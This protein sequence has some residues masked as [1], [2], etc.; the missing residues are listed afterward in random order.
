MIAMSR[1]VLALAGAAGGLAMIVAAG[2][3]RAQA[4][5]EADPTC[6]S[7]VM[8]SGVITVANGQQFAIV[9]PSNRTTGYSWQFAQLYD[10]SVVRLV[11]Y[12]YLPAVPSGPGPIPPGQIPLGAGNLPGSSAPIG[13]GGEECWVFQAVG[14]GT[15]TI[16]LQYV[17]P[18]ETDVAPAQYMTFEVQVD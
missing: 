7:G 16:A 4:P 5:I 6:F 18:W 13:A 9:L 3:A 1:L 15:T 2:T 12:D 14:A 17:R 11:H 8:D 10:E